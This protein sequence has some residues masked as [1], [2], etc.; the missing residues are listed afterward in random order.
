MTTLKDQQDEVLRKITE[1]N[2][3]AD[4]AVKVLKLEPMQAEVFSKACADRF[5]WD[6][7]S[8]LFKGANGNVA[9]D[10]EQCTGFFQR[11]YGF[12]FPPKQAG[13]ENHAEID[14]ALLASARAGNMT[15]RAR[16][17]RDSLNG[18][19]KRL[20][21]VLADEGN[22]D[23]D[24]AANGGGISGALNGHGSNPFT[25]LRDH[26]GKIVPA[27][28]KQ[29]QGMIR[30]MGTKKVAAIA[31]AVNKTITGLPLRAS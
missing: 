22:G 5:V 9:A 25:K 27:V 12:L 20:D 29:I 8:L 31:A 26:T 17:V 19:V 11:E 10:D 2:K 16:I 7:V 24:A 23:D 14:P 13:S 1:K 6:G 28:E 21:A 15:A 3:V 4:F 30:S 18:D